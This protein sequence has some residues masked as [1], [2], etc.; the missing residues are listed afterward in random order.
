MV[1]LKRRRKLARLLRRF[2]SGELTNDQY[3]DRAMTLRPHVSRSSKDLA[4][5]K[6]I[7]ASWLLYS[8]LCEHRLTGKHALHRESRRIVTRWILFLYSNLEYRWPQRESSIRDIVLSILTL[9]M[10]GARERMKFG[11][12]FRASGD[13]DVWPFS[14]RRDYETELNCP[15]RIVT[16]Q[17]TA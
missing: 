17:Q 11:T 10:H 3:E 5:S 12:E 14:C 2:L 8:D 4:V 1:D 6:I 16:F 13:V 7:D 9:G 15:F